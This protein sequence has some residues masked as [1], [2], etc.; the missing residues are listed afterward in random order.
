MLGSGTRV[1]RFISCGSVS[2][3]SLD[4]VHSL[5]STVPVWLQATASFRD[6]MSLTSCRHHHNIDTKTTSDGP[7]TRQNIRELCYIMSTTLKDTMPPSRLAPLLRLPNEVMLS[8][9]RY[10]AVSPIPFNLAPSSFTN[11]NSRK[12]LA[13]WK[14]YASLGQTCKTLRVLLDNDQ[15]FFK[16]NTFV[17]GP[18]NQLCWQLQQMPS[19][20]RRAL[21][22]V[23]FLPWIFYK[24]VEN[25]HTNH[26]Y[27]REVHAIRSFSD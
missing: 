11:S 27:L 4:V 26:H 2:L 15:T 10:L 12:N 3:L 5:Q 23:A 24:D 18:A 14:I 20:S 16:H 1:S 19:K 22:D 13:R 17:S 25:K 21:R 7:E 6:P 9:V 8:I